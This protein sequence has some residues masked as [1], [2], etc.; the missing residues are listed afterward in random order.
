LSGRWAS[1]P[2]SICRWSEEPETPRLLHFGR[3]AKT[4]Q[5]PNPI[6]MNMI[7]AKIF[8]GES[9]IVDSY[10]LNYWAVTATM[11]VVIG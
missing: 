2:R 1:F 3:L 10:K 7:E 4:L 11:D 5:T 9:C 8:G 6:S